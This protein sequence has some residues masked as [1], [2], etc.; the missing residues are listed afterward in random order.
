VNKHS[1][2]NWSMLYVRGECQ[3]IRVEEQ[4]EEEEEIERQSSA[5]SETP[6]QAVGDDLEPLVIRPRGV[7]AHAEI[8]STV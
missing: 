8:E 4:E 1:N 3:H 5:C 7:A 2:R 6:C